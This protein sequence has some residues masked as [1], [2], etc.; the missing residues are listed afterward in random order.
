MREL[1][2]KKSR[3]CDYAYGRERDWLG[4]VSSGVSF[5]KSDFFFFLNAD[6]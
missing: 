4:F 6:V 1:K 5:F 3:V 2:K